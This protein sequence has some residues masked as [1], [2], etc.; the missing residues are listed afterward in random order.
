MAKDIV[1]ELLDKIK[2]DFHLSTSQSEVIKKAIDDLD[3]GKATYKTANGFAK[4]L[5]DILA[6]TLQSN[7][8]ADVLPDGKMYYNIANR[9]LNDTMRAN[10]EAVAEFSKDV[11]TSLNHSAG[12]GI[13]GRK[14]EL[15]QDRIDGLVERIS[16]SEDIDFIKKTLGEPIVNFTQSIVDDTI[17]TNADF[18]DKLGLKPKIIRTSTGKCCSWCSKVAGIYDYKDVKNTGN[19]V[20]RRHQHCR[21]EI[22]YHPGDGRKQNVHTKKWKDAETNDNLTIPKSLSASGKNYPV[23][24]L[25]SKNRTKFVEGQ[26]I[27][28]TVFAGKGTDVEIRDRFRLESFYKIPADE[29]KKVSG[30]GYIVIEGKE[31]KAEIHWYEAFDQKVEMK[32]VRYFDED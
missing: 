22:D 28:P 25:G 21:C 18:H 12:L 29:W 27:K 7:I 17:K 32:V 10:Y 31:V 20:F 4:E 16:E 24:L 1:P 15:N 30:I 9:I 6:K 3:L 23:K 8:N 26:E 5:G 11:Q 2:K 19:N 14:A 13:R